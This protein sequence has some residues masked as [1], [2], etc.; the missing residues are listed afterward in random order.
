MMILNAANY[1]VSWI[2]LILVNWERQD[3]GEIGKHK[4]VQGTGWCSMH[5]TDTKIE[6]LPRFM[7]PDCMCSFFNKVR[8]SSN[9][10]WLKREILKLWLMT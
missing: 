6:V 5:F 8:E 2:C 1:T 9:F 4:L 3:G 10:L 7:Y